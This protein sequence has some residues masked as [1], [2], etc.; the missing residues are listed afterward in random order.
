MTT[1][2]FVAAYLQASK[3]AAILHKMHLRKKHADAEWDAL[4]DGMFALQA[5]A[6]KSVEHARD[7][8]ELLFCFDG[9]TVLQGGAA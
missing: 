6:S 7:V 5:M 2:L 1:I 8:G 9:T 4:W 3:N